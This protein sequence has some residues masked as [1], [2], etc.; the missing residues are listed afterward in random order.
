MNI[1]TYVIKGEPMWRPI[2]YTP[3]K[4]DSDRFGHR[5][6][7]W[8]V[9]VDNQ[10]EHA[11]DKSIELEAHFYQLKNKTPIPLLRMMRFIEETGGGI[12]FKTF[13]SLVSFKGE[14]HQTDTNARTVLIVK[15]VS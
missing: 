13:T 1:Y 2:V 11:L 12:L 14:M 7:L 6:R 10:V 9:S 5:K 3:T 4:I 8:I 15:E